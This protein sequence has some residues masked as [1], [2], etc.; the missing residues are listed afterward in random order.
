MKVY[1]KKD[2]TIENMEREGDLIPYCLPKSGVHVELSTHF[3]DGK[4]VYKKAT[5]RAGK[6]WTIRK[7]SSIT[8]FRKAV[9]ICHV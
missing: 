4:R 5:Y 8:K 7:F 2:I 9:T 6:G 1:N 3:E